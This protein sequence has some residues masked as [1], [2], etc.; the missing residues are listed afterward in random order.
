MLLLLRQASQ[1]NVFAPECPKL[2]SLCLPTPGT[3]R[4]QGYKEAREFLPNFRCRNIFD[5]SDE[6]GNS[7][8]MKWIRIVPSGAFR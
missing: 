2:G 6:A 3:R 5:I 1:E 4:L 7:N 8:A